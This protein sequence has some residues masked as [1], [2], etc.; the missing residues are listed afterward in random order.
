[1][2]GARETALASS[3]YKPFMWRL[4]KFRGWNWKFH[5]IIVINTDLSG[6]VVPMRRVRQIP[7][8]D[9]LGILLPVSHAPSCIGTTNPSRTGLNPLNQHCKIIHWEQFVPNNNHLRAT[10]QGRHWSWWFVKREGSGHSIS[11]L[12]YFSPKVFMC[13]SKYR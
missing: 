13:H 10:Y 5:V 2:G 8:A 4:L 1:M 9:A 12:C 6:F 7:R 11:F 3:T